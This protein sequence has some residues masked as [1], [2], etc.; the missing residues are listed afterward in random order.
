LE[1]RIF[2]FEVT[3]LLDLLDVYVIRT[4]DDSSGL[5]ADKGG[6]APRFHVVGSAL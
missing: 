1:I 4:L 5:L 6:Q 2:I 3:R